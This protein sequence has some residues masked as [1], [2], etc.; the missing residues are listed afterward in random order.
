M[1]V[2]DDCCSGTDTCEGIFDKR[3][4]GFTVLNKLRKN[5]DTDF[6]FM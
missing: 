1:P 2:S 3:K 5:I 4:N 6:F